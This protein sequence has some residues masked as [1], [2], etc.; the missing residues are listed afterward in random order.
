[1][2]AIFVIMSIHH[3]ELLAYIVHCESHL[4][5]D[6]DYS[7]VF[8]SQ[9]PSRVSLLQFAISSDSDNCAYLKIIDCSGLGIQM[10][11][12]HSLPP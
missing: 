10:S 6:N 8:I 5:S 9:V 1:M 12:F 2:Q 11:G 3:T 4:L 7:F